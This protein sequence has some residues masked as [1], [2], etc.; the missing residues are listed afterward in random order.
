METYESLEALLQSPKLSAL[1]KEK[2]FNVHSVEII[3]ALKDHDDRIRTVVNEE[4]QRFLLQKHVLVTTPDYEVVD[5]EVVAFDIGEIDIRF[6]NAV[7]FGSNLFQLPFLCTVMAEIDF[8]IY[9]AD[10]YGQSDEE[11]QQYEVWDADW[12]D[13]H[14]H[15]SRACPCTVADA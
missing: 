7:Y 9:K 14:M 10:F 4:V 11:Q 2:F 3:E 15:V 6:E 8:I 1:S 5:G 13:R 12:N